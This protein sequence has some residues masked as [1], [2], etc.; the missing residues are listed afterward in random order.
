M[1]HERLASRAELCEEQNYNAVSGILSFG[2]TSCGC[3]EGHHVGEPIHQVECSIALRFDALGSF[4]AFL[5]FI[6]FVFG[7]A[8]SVGVL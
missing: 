7:T 2:A 5:G 4:V 8:A 6:D 1:W 3:Q